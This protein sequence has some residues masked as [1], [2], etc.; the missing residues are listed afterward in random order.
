MFI[1]NSAPLHEGRENHDL[2]MDLM[3]AVDDVTSAMETVVTELTKTRNESAS[4][5]TEYHFDEN[6]QE[7]KG[8]DNVWNGEENNTRVKMKVMSH[9]GGAIAAC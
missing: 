9:K 1:G 4:S 7:G 2:R 6:D 3:N 8:D 5:T